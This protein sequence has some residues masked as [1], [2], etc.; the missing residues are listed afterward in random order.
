MV[1]PILCMAVLAVV[2]LS[3]G[4]SLL[5]VWLIVRAGRALLLGAGW[6]SVVAL[7]EL[8]IRLRSRLRQVSFKHLLERGL[9]LI[10]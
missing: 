4:I 10:Q 6:R 5:P 9:G 3:T 2:G 1:E 8:V 7:W